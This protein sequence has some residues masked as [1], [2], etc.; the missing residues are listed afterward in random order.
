MRENFIPLI[1][2]LTIS[3]S[4]KANGSKGRKSELLCMHLEE[5]HEQK[6]LK[7]V[8]Q[9]REP[10]VGKWGHILGVGKWGHILGIG[11]WGHI[12]MS[13]LQNDRMSLQYAVLQ[14]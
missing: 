13:V 11:K 12:V 10:R 6:L 5:S 14:D 8:S 4:E 3:L 9:G 1:T 2:I 7:S